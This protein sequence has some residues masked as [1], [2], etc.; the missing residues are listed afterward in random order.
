MVSDAVQGPNVICVQIERGAS[1]TEDEL[2][3]YASSNF[4]RVMNCVMYADRGYA[5]VEFAQTA[6]ADRALASAY[7][8]INGVKIRCRPRQQSTKFQTTVPSST[9]LLHIGNFGSIDEEKVLLHFP[10]LQQISSYRDAHG[11]MY[12]RGAVDADAGDQLLSRRAFCLNGRVLHVFLDTNDYQSNDWQNSLLVRPVPQRLAD[13]NLLDYFSQFGSIVN[14][15]RQG[16]TDTYRIEYRDRTD[17][18]GLLESDRPHLI[19]SVRLKIESVSR[20]MKSKRN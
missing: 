11:Q 17:L 2:Y 19:K 16:L 5:F 1:I 7:H 6:D 9:P 15:Y 20:E 8:T 14:C 10:Q 12:L 13:Y 4:G 3:E 18:N